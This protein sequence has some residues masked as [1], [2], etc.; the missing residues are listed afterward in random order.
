MRMIRIFACLTATFALSALGA[1]SASAAVEF[2]SPIHPAEVKSL[3]TNVQ[4]FNGSGVVIACPRLAADTGEEIG[5]KITEGEATNPKE[6]KPTLNVHPIYGGPAASEECRGTLG[7]GSFQV[8]VRTKGCNF[9]TK[10][11][12]PN[13]GV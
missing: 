10:A 1:A 8:E 3:N 6:N 7:I 2:D 11:F 4:G 5:K 12:K 13:A 9:V